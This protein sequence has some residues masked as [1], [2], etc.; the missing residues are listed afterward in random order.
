VNASLSPSLEGYVRAHERRAERSAV[1]FGVA[2]PVLFVLGF[3]I[4]AGGAL[5]GPKPLHSYD[6]VGP[7]S[8]GTREQCLAVHERFAKEDRIERLQLALGLAAFFSLPL[9]VISVIQRRNRSGPRDVL[10]D[11]N[12]VARFYQVITKLNGVPVA[13]SVAIQHL[14]GRTVQLASSPTEAQHVMAELHRHA[15]TA[16]VGFE[17]F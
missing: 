5:F 12:D 3:L 2:S 8:Y 14:S 10:A 1:I 11:P 4:V 6:C 16:I 9:L 13:R 17:A 15:P 7:T